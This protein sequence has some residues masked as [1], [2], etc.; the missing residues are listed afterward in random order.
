MGGRSVSVEPEA[1]AFTVR[2]GAAAWL[3]ERLATGGEAGWAVVG[4]E[5]G[6]GGEGGGGGECGRVG[7]G[8]G[9]G[10]GVLR[11]RCRRGCGDDG[12]SVAEIELVT[13]DGGDIGVGRA[14]SVSIHRERWR[15]GLAERKARHRREVVLDAD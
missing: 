2:A 12:R 15:G 3:S 4:G 9:G 5:T 10:V 13:G 1:S 8:A 14:R 6:G 7:V 11:G